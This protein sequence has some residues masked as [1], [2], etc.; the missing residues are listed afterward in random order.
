MLLRE[1]YDSSSLSVLILRYL[2]SGWRWRWL[3]LSISYENI[4]EL[5]TAVKVYRFVF[6]TRCRLLSLIACQLD[7]LVYI[8]KKRQLQTLH[9]KPTNTQLFPL[10]IFLSQTSQRQPS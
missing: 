8:D 10:Q 6:L 2:T 1:E 9:T 5:R 3:W 7:F 4:P